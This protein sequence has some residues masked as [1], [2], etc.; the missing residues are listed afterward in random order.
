MVLAT[1]QSESANVSECMQ[2]HNAMFWLVRRTAMAM[3]CVLTKE[4]VAA[5]LAG[6]VKIVQ[7]TNAIRNAC[8]VH[9]T[10]VLESASAILDIS[11]KI[12][13]RK[14]VTVRVYHA[15]IRSVSAEG[16]MHNQHATTM[17]ENASVTREF[18]SPNTSS[19]HFVPR[20]NAQVLVMRKHRSV[21][22]LV[23]ASVIMRLEYA[24]VI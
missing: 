17:R 1:P 9:A 10:E 13:A 4:S 5:I 6:S 8:M 15:T 16:P 23:M 18:R 14:N 2:G 19:R 3:G 11:Q 7:S 21:L 12:A 22:A 24:S 20:G